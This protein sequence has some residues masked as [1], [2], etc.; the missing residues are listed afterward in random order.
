MFIWQDEEIKLRRNRKS[1][2]NIKDV[3]DDES[4]DETGTPS[5]SDVEENVNL[6]SHDIIEQSATKSG[7]QKRHNI[8]QRVLGDE[9][10]H[11]SHTGVSVES[12]GEKSISISN[13]V[14][15]IV[16]CVVEQGNNELTT[17]KLKL[18][19]SQRLDSRKRRYSGSSISSVS[20]TTSK[21]SRIPGFAITPIKHKMDIIRNSPKKLKQ[22][23]SNFDSDIDDVYDR[24]LLQQNLHDSF[25]MFEH[26]S[27]SQSFLK[28]KS[29]SHSVCKESPTNKPSSNLGTRSPSKS[30]RKYVSGF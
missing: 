14:T 1:K 2:K 30:K 25:S 24:D 17:D 11:D 8:E 6:C 28:S 15:D 9:D 7:D 4:H 19:S 10:S 27:T 22:S 29:I 18:I 16:S 3:K 21:S 12:R 20:S 13:T 26:P 23:Q 5:E